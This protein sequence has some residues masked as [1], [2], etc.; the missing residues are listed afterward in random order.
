M[1]FHQNVPKCWVTISIRKWGNIYEK[2]NTHTRIHIIESLI[3]TFL[4]SLG[5]KNI[6]QFSKY[7]LYFIGKRVNY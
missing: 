7:L 4:V 3:H 5:I 6:T 1:N 2:K